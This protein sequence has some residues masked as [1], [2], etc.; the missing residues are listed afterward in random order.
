MFNNGLKLGNFIGKFRSLEQNR[1]AMKKNDVKTAC[2]SFL[3]LILALSGCRKSD[4]VADRI[5]FNARI[6]TGDPANPSAGALGTVGEEILFVG[7]DYEKW[8]G[9]ATEMI[10]LTGAMIVP[11]FIDNHVHFLE[12]GFQLAGVDLRSARTP[13]EFSNVLGAFASNLPEGRWITGGSWDHEAW[14]GELP[15]REWIDSLTG[16]NP[17]FVSRLDGHMALANTIALTM[18]GITKETPDPE[19]GTIVR[20]PATGE[21]TGVLKDEAMS[22]V[23]AVMPAP[24]EQEM[25]EALARAMDHAVSLGITQVHDVSSFGG[26]RDLATYRRAHEK[27]VLKT[28]IYSFVPIAT[29]TRLDTF[30]QQNGR[31]DDMLRWGALK[32]FVDGSLGS[33][34]AWF[35]DP[36]SDAPETSGLMVTDTAALRQW[37]LQADAAGFHLGIHAIGDQ[38]NDWLLGVFEEAIRQ[39]GSRDRRFRIEHSQHLTRGAINRFA[40]LGV[41]PSMQPYHAIDDGRWAEK[42]IGPERI[43]TTYAFRS[44]LDAGARLTFGSDWVVA[45]LSPLEGIYAAVTRRTL[46]GAN[47]EGWVPQEKISIDEA[48]KCYTANNAYAGFQ[49]NKTGMLKAGMWADFAVLSEDLFQIAPERIKDVKVLRTVVGGKEMSY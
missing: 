36:Y 6:W 15:R 49:E 29:W 3:G 4:T 1:K 39:N 19:G 37:I 21:P 8:R 40:E 11:G 24:S 7:D 34:T 18:A 45:P 23:F 13:E 17:V 2:L 20:D 28:R 46:D 35:Y 30:V 14:G 26:W 41:I 27:G 38:A 12:G 16:N 44:L 9:S 25:D 5:Y 33:T 42:R 10:D 48:L 22:L 31:G 47:P 32:G 43:K